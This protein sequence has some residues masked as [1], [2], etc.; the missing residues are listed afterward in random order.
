[1]GRKSERL[2]KRT[3]LEIIRDIVIS[4]KKETEESPE[5]KGG[6][7]TYILYRTHLGGQQIYYFDVALEAGL[8]EP[9]TDD[10]RT[11][12]KPSQKGF[13]YLEILKKGPI[14]DVNRL[15]KE[16]RIN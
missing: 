4:T 2:E 13:D 10:S 16:K 1:M 5:K 9:V 8:I 7:K 6:L 14:A 15:I 12:Y 3:K 11:R